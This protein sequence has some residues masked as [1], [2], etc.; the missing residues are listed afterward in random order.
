MSGYGFKMAM[1]ALV[2]YNRTLH[3]MV[4]MEYWEGCMEYSFVTP[5][6]M[7]SYHLNSNQKYRR[8]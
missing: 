4:S 5:E 7:E 3:V 1:F 2:K 6:S 8:I